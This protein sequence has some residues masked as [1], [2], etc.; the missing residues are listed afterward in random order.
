MTNLNYFF[1]AVIFTFKEA[2][3]NYKGNNSG[4]QGTETI[5]RTANTSKQDLISG[6]V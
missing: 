5:N 4:S 6:D 2:F 3:S 1:T